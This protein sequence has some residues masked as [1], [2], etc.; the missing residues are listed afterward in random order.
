MP[1]AINRYSGTLI[2]TVADGTIDNTTDIKIIGKNYAGYGEVQNENFLYLLE[3]FANNNPPPRPLSGQVWYDSSNKK[4]KFYDGSKFRTTGGAEVGPTPPTGLTIGDF[5]FDTANSQLNAWDGSQFVLVGPQG[6]PGATTTQMETASLRDTTGTAHRVILSKVNGQTV[7]VISNEQGSNA[8][9]SWTLQTPFAGFQKI[10]QGVTLAYTTDDAYPGQTTTN[11]RLHATATNSDRLGGKAYTDFVLKTDAQFTAPV[12][13]ADTG[14]TVGGTPKLRIYNAGEVPTIYNQYGNTIVF[15]TTDGSEKVPLQLV[16]INVRPGSD[17]ATD[18]G[19]PL[20]RFKTVNAVSFNGVATQASQ[21]AVG[22]EYKSASTASSAGTIVAR[23]ASDE[24][25]NGVN[26]LAGAVKG[27][28]FVGTATSANYADLAEKYLADADYEVGT[29]VA[30]GGEKEVTASKWGDRAIGAVSANPAYMMNAE[31][32]GGTFIAL[33]GRV[34]V[35][36]VGAVRKGQRMVAG[37]DGTAVAA[38]PH[39]NDVFAIALESSD[40]VGIKLVECLI[41]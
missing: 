6:A 40:E 20:L 27:T 17:N 23:T 26:I 24:T 29:V 12:N 11:Y 35:K 19:S 21:L 16:G 2:A 37:N 36:V 5:W 22:S 8:D 15:K 33:K 14:F 25:I 32:E 41:L 10:Y 1:Y 4:L 31:L 7:F 28:Y 9:G 38:V 3:N 30:V 39:A 34:P 18:L 13:F